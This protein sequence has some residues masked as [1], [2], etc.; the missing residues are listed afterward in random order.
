M[1]PRFR[2]FHQ[3]QRPGVR[4]QLDAALGL[5]QRRKHSQQDKPHAT[6]VRFC[7]HTVDAVQGAPCL[8]ILIL[9]QPLPTRPGDLRTLLGKVMLQQLLHC[10]QPLPQLGVS[11]L[12]R[13]AYQLSRQLIQLLGQGLIVS[14]VF[15]VQRAGPQTADETRIAQAQYRMDANNGMCQLLNMMQLHRVT[16]GIQEA[17][18]GTNRAVIG[19]F[20]FTAVINSVEVIFAFDPQRRKVAVTGEMSMADVF[21]TEGKDHL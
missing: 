7:H 5:Q 4:I 10:C 18:P 15:I 17:A 21:L 13:V 3:Q 1:Q 11:Q 19:Q 20:A 16:V 12:L 14:R 9:I 6:A 8:L 2:V